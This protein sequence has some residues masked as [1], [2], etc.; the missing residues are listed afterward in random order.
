[1]AQTRTFEYLADDR[2]I[3][4][5]TW[6]LGSLVP[7]RYRGYD[8]APGS[9][10]NLVLNHD[11]TGYQFT[12]ATNAISAN[13]SFALTK[14][15][16]VIKEDAAVTI[17]ISPGDTT[18]PRIDIIVLRHQRVELSGGAQ[19]TYHVIQGTPS[20]K[21]V[22][23]EGAVTSNEIVL[24]RLTV[25]AG[26]SA[27]NA[28]GVEYVQDPA[29]AYADDLTRFN[30]LQAQ[31]TALE[32]SVQANTSAIALRVLQSAFD[33]AIQTLTNTT[34]TLTN[35]TNNHTSRITA[36][37][38]LIIKEDSP[39]VGNITKHLGIGSGGLETI[40]ASGKMILFSF[41]P[42]DLDNTLGTRGLFFWV[43]FEYAREGSDNDD[44]AVRLKWINGPAANPG[45]PVT[46]AQQYIVPALNDSQRITLPF[47]MNVTTPP[48]TGQV[49]R[50][51]IQF[52]E[53][54]E[55]FPVKVSSNLNLNIIYMVN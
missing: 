2:T 6:L 37:E 8:F 16:T 19:A 33:S 20:S 4:I 35:T 9:D 24:G 50:A 42:D 27:L 32:T 1:M 52:Q 12:L 7:G 51:G 55:S 34:N 44:L 41:S 10:L 13:H 39:P 3:D 46:I 11:T 29:P 36:L 30:A 15:G 53:L 21:P 48:T 45:T 23:N 17:P 5:N 31:I 22:A 14:H 38:G 43:S 40:P 54:N 25:P 18:H 28:S 26:T 49:F 47:H